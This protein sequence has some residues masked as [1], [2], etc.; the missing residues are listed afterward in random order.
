[1]LVKMQPHGISPD[2]KFSFNV[3]NV[4]RAPSKDDAIGMLPWG[5]IKFLDFSELP[6][7]YDIA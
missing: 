3:A 2:A 7:A 4:L 5:V 1:M 6:Y